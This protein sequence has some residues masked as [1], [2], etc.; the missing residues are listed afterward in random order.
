VRICI[1]DL[2]PSAGAWELEAYEPSD[3][4]L[5]EVYNNGGRVRVYSRWFIDQI[6]RT[7]QGEIR[8]NPIC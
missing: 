3:L 8:S 2:S 4:W 5:I 7:K 1:D 6:A